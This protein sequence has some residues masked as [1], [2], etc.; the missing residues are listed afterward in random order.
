MNAPSWKEEINFICGGQDLLQW[1]ARDPKIKGTTIKVNAYCAS[2]IYNFH[3]NNKG[4]TDWT[5]DN[6]Y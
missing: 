6:K 1:E 2:F 3:M 4:C 5:K